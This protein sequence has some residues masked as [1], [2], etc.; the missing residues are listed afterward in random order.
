MLEVWGVG[1]RTPEEPAAAVWPTYQVGTPCAGTH[2]ERPDAAPAPQGLAVGGRSGPAR[3]LALDARPRGACSG[4]ATTGSGE[5]QGGGANAWCLEEAASVGA[6]A[7]ESRAHGQCPYD[8][9]VL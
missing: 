6:R 3:R 7:R 2:T 1:Y 9:R 5:A 8:S 4:A